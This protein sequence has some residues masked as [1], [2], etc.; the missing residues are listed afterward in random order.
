MIVKKG[1][2]TSFY[3][4]KK[5]D[6]KGLFLKFF[7]TAE[8]A[9]SSDSIWI[10]EFEP[11]GYAKM[12]SHKEEHYLY[13]MNGVCTVRKPGEEDLTAAEGDCIYISSCEEHEIENTGDLPLKMVSF[14]AILK[15]ATGRST[16][17]CR[18]I[19]K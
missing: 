1:I 9:G 11:H 8:D 2:N 5:D 19:K 4:V 18:N 13:V 14:M 3:E 12:H 15:G 7:I 10:M 6:I 17:P 16:T